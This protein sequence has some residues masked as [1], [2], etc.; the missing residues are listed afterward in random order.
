MRNSWSE[1]CFFPGAVV[2][3]GGVR[4]QIEDL[5]EAPSFWDVAGTIVSLPAGADETAAEAGGGALRGVSPIN[6]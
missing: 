6:H 5:I 2:H 1:R 3:V 4:R